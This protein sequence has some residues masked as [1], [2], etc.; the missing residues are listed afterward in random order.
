M[1]YARSFHPSRS[2]DILE[3]GLGGAAHGKGLVAIGNGFE[4]APPLPGALLL[5]RRRGGASRDLSLAAGG[6][7]GFDA[8]GG[9]V[10]GGGDRGIKVAPEVPNAAGFGE[11]V[12]H[13]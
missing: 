6:G 11:H 8:G 10:D 4:K 13:G 3:L 2:R 7:V 12:S 5:R 1:R 9:G